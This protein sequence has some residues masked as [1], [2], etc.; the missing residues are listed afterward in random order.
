M[1]RALLSDVRVWLVFAFAV[2]LTGVFVLPLWLPEILQLMATTQRSFPIM[3]NWI[4]ATPHAAPLGYL[5]QFPLVWILGH[6]AWVARLPSLA[7][8]LGSCYLLWRLAK[9]IGIQQPILALVLFLI[10]PIQYRFAIEATV[11]EEALFFSILAALCFLT[12]VETP[13]VWNA[14]RYALALTL[15]LYTEPLSFLPAAGYLLFVVAFIVRK[16]MR[17]ALWHI[18]PATALPVLLFGPYFA[19]TRQFQFS[20]W[21]LA[22]DS[23]SFLPSTW[24]MIFRDLTGGGDVGYI[25]TAIVLLGVG[26][27]TWRASRLTEGAHAKRVAL[28]CLLGGVVSTVVIVL[29]LDNQ[30]ELPFSPSQFLWAAPGLIIL[31]TAAL[32]WVSSKNKYLAYALAAIFVGFSVAGDYT[33]LT[34]RTENVAKLTALVG[35][36]LQGDSCVVYLSEGLLTHEMFFIFDPSLRSRECTQFFHHRI[37]L[38]S[39]PYVRADQQRDGETYFRG[40][41]F[42]EAKRV[43]AGDGLLLVLDQKAK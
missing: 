12:L 35:P 28:F 22:T 11:F 34:T 7:F 42:I 2:L 39:H 37:L 18:L 10:L 17:L 6:S 5:T 32:D 19:W 15:C 30:S 13:T 41:D 23:Y 25:L 21:L 3:L 20:N 31:L 36:E 38:L 4:K 14:G 29:I 27:A 8:G 40:L 43:A 33:L 16:E 1:N 26:V 24:P 9:K